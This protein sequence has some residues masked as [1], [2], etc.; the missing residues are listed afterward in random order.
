VGGFAVNWYY[1]AQ[2]ERRDAEYKAKADQRQQAEHEARMAR[3]RRGASSDT[4][5][6]GLS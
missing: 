1:K 4:D 6:G 3:L 5:Q 2:A